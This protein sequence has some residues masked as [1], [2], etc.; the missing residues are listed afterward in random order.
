ME[1]IF[2]KGIGDLFVA[3]VAGN[4][5]N[6]DILGSMEFG[7]KVSGA[8]LVLVLGHKSCGAIKSAIDDVKLGNITAMLSKIKPAIGKSQDFSGD[9]NSKNDD[10]VE[11][12]A[13]R[14]C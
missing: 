10:Y 9:K 3:R 13:K 1:D 8:K 12:V 11:Y 5:V 7:C 14:M 6:E 4:F 2:D